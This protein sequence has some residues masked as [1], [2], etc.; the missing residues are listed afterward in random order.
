VVTAELVGGLGNQCFIYATAR[1]LSL[2]LNTDL[3]LNVS[4]VDSDPIRDYGL[5]CF[6]GVTAPIV[7]ES[8]GRIIEHW[9]M[10]YKP[11]LLEGIE[12]DVTL[13]GYWQ[14]EKYFKDCEKQIQ[15]DFQFTRISSVADITSLVMKSP[16]S[17]SIHIRRGDYLT[18]ATQKVMGILSEDYYM[19]ATN[20]IQERVSPSVLF[21]F[22]DDSEHAETQFK[23]SPV[24]SG[25]KDY[26]D[27]WL[28][29][30]SKHHVIAN[31]SFSW[32]GSWL[33]DQSGITI[34]PKRWFT[35]MDSSDLIPSRWI[36][37]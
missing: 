6:K 3:K 20:Y 15:E 16:Y 2:R 21:V 8:K 7:W 13:R 5:G 24:V 12:G 31:S 22:S 1:A 4:R 9:G 29:S 14:S 36:R 10:E 18:E 30:R 35:E 27:M 19:A 23:C 37:L 11:A 34:A 17:V 26:E 28:M 25:L 32:W 33:G